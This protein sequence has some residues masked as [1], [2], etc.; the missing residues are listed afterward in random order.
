MAKAIKNVLL[1]GEYYESFKFCFLPL[2]TKPSKFYLSTGQQENLIIPW[3]STMN[4]VSIAFSYLFLY[5]FHSKYTSDTSKGESYNW[6]FYN[7]LFL[8][9]MTC[10]S[11]DQGSININRHFH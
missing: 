2:Q 5:W 4:F 8:I 1:V 10:F 9:S 6:V 3:D 11:C 7:K